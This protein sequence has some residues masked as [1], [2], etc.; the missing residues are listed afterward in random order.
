MNT[1]P[2]KAACQGWNS[3]LLSVLIIPSPSLHDQDDMQP[4]HEERDKFLAGFGEP[5]LRCHPPVMH[6]PPDLPRN[7]NASTRIVPGVASP[8]EASRSSSVPPPHIGK[9]RLAVNR[10]QITHGPQTSGLKSKAS[11]GLL[12]IETCTFRKATTR[13]ACHSKQ[14]SR[15]LSDRQATR[16]GCHFRQQATCLTT[17]QIP[18]DIVE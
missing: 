10:V 7:G 13:I 9:C 5:A 2:L 17:K 11:A 3:H 4:C 1:P 15:A 16:V 12:T 18:K 14:Q 6:Q 8:A